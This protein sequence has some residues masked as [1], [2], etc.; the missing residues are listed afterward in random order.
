MDDRAVRDWAAVQMGCERAS[1]PAG[2]SSG[3]PI[4]PQTT[5]EFSWPSASSSVSA[6]DAQH[7]ERP[8]LRDRRLPARSSSCRDSLRSVK[9]MPGWPQRDRL[10]RL[11]TIRP[12]SLASLFRNFAAPAY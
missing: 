11:S 4:N 7:V 6:A 12:D 5:I 2:A 9:R 10:D 8:P 3:R 1:P